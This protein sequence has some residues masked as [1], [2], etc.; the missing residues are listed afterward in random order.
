MPEIV[1]PVMSP[2]EV[3]ADLDAVLRDQPR[4][5][6]T[7]H[8]VAG[9]RD[10]H[11]ADEN[12]GLLEVGDQA[13]GHGERLV[14]IRRRVGRVDRLA[15]L[16]AVE[17]PVAHL[18]HG[19]VVERAARIHIGDADIVEHGR[20]RRADHG[21]AGGGLAVAVDGEVRDRHI[22]DPDHRHDRIDRARSG[23]RV[24]RIE[25]GADDIGRRLDHHAGVRSVER[26]RARAHADDRQ[27]CEAGRVRRERAVDDHL[28]LQLGA[29]EDADGGIGLADRVHRRLQ[30]IE[31]GNEMI[32]AVEQPHRLGEIKHGC[33]RIRWP[34]RRSACRYPHG[35]RHRWCRRRRRHRGPGP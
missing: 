22:R 31:R 10:I 16:D 5:I 2:V 4:R 7:G 34:P 15:A 20:G 1:L 9:Q 24:P 13:V 29:A 33:R 32:I 11:V 30:R 25:S 35:C 27:A 14:V 17:R 12:A 8:G 19:D 6:C 18:L 3:L 23:A 28:L 26:G 21:V